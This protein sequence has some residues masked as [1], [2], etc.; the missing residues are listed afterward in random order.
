MLFRSGMVG[1]APDEVSARLVRGEGVLSRAGVNNIGG[2][3]AV[4]AA[5]AG[6]S[7]PPMVVA[8][9]QYRHQSFRPFIRH[10]LRL[11]GDLTDAIRGT[12]TVGMREAL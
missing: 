7:S 10:H 3:A 4:Q 5:N 6:V 9:H 12:R 8:I 11:G 2:A 1:A